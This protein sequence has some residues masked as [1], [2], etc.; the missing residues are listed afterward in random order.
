MKYS[1]MGQTIKYYVIYMWSTEKRA[2]LEQLI[3]SA[4][5]HIN[6]HC[7]PRDCSLNCLHHA[8][9]SNAKLPPPRHS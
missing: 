6:E 8:T 7:F 1:P 5:K 3:K 9:A 4:E 2:W